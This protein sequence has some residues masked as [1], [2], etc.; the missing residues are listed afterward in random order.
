MGIQRIESV[1][2]TVDDLNTNV[3]FFEDF[4]L[5][6][7]SRDDTRAVFGTRIGQT[8]HLDTTERPDLPAPS[9][10]RWEAGTG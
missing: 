7:V 8:L 2:Y 10:D 4:G 1:T 3:R 5:T 6:L 9:R